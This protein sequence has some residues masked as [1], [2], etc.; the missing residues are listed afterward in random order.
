MGKVRAMRVAEGIR[1]EVGELLLR[2]VKDPR[3]KRFHVTRVEVSQD[4][5]VARVHVGFLGPEAEEA[6]AFAALERA[7]GFFRSEV[8][9]VLGLRHAPEIRFHLDPSARHS[10][11]IQ[12]LLREVRE[13]ASASPGFAQNSQE[14][15]GGTF[16][17]PHG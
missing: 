15:E 2:G 1:R 9:K 14:P 17:E 6:A 10:Q 13:E 7:A 8:G 5:S 12:E 3:L 4:L 11:R 16:E